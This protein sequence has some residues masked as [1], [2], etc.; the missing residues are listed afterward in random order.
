MCRD[1][2]SHAPD[3]QLSGFEH[4]QQEINKQFISLAGFQKTN[5]IRSAGIFYCHGDTSDSPSPLTRPHGSNQAWNSIVSCFW[6]PESN[7]KWRGFFF[8]LVSHIYQLQQKKNFY[9]VIL[10]YKFNLFS[11]SNTSPRTLFLLYHNN[12]LPFYIVKTKHM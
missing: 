8:C 12:F 10:F 7:Q 3:F 2:I 5:A 6:R 11:Q 4:H 9:P 1:V